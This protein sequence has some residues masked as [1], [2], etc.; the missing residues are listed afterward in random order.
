M[1]TF[2]ADS[3]RNPHDALLHITFLSDS[4]TTNYLRKVIRSNETITTYYV[5]GQSGDASDI[6]PSRS[7]ILRQQPLVVR[8]HVTQPPHE[9]ARDA[10]RRLAIEQQLR[11]QFV[12]ALLPTVRHRVTGPGARRAS[13]GWRA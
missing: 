6:A 8:Q 4:N 1:H 2:L 11:L 12:I 10:S 7:S 13:T 5:P 3:I 9:V